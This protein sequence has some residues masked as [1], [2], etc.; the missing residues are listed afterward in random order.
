M[1]LAVALA[2]VAL[3]AALVAPS[4][5]SQLAAAELRERAEALVSALS[6]ARSEAIKHGARV[7]LCPSA[8]RVTCA[9]SGEWEAGWLAFPNDA[10]T[11]PPG[12][13]AAVLAR[14]PAARPGI[15]IRGNSPVARYVSY[16]S[17]GHARRRD[18]ALQMGSFV[19]CRPGAAAL[20][21]VLANS[22]RTRIDAT[23][24][25]CP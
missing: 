3:V 8:D 24:E 9:A 7:D 15:T 20:K 6:R 23:G 21:V 13:V 1:E 10:A 16:T 22:G 12:A 4:W 25:A 5:R 14:E 19:V 17:L 18:G 2:V 11:D